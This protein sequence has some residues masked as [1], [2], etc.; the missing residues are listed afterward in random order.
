MINQE[1]SQENSTQQLPEDFDY[2]MYINLNHDLRYMSEIEA[3]KHYKTQGY[4]E[5]RKYK[6]SQF[7]LNYSVYIFCNGKSGSSTLYTTFKKCGYNTLH[8]HGIKNYEA[9]AEYYLN[10][11]IFNV[12]EN[13]MKNN[14]NVYVIDSYRTPIERKISSFFQNYN[15]I[16]KDIDYIT[17]QIDKEIIKLENYEASDE[18]LYHFKLDHFTMFDFKKKYN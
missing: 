9:H 12:I 2:K 8:L 11:N 16:N 13:S 15:N 14:E 10:S 1:Q 17:Q 7:D 3:K 18:I 5:E 6:S 4:L